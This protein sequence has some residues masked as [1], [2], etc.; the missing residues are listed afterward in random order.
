MNSPEQGSSNLVSLI[1]LLGRR[2]QQTVTRRSTGQPVSH[3]T[4]HAL[5]ADLQQLWHKQIARTNRCS[6]EGT[7]FD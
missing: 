1:S 6:P 4:P 3:E 7:A 5:A 2:G